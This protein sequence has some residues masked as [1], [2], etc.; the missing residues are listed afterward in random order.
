MIT[1]N[2]KGGILKRE[3]RLKFKEIKLKKAAVKKAAF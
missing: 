2:K 1:P 3:H